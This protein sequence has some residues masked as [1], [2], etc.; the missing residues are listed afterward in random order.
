MVRTSPSRCGESRTRGRG[1]SGRAKAHVAGPSWGRT[2]L[3]SERGFDGGFDD[4]TGFVGGRPAIDELFSATYEELRRMAASVRATDAR[5]TLNPTALVNEAWLKLAASRSL[6]VASVLHFKRIAARAIRQVLV[7]AARQRNADKRGAGVAPV[8]FEEALAP[9]GE[10]RAEDV[11][12]IDNAL[13]E[14]RRM[15]PRHAA[16]V[17]SRFFGGLEIPEIAQLLNVSEATVLRDW[18]AARA[19]LAKELRGGP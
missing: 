12:A 7:E 5:A 6:Q 8:V 9:A 15:N 13:D 10:E 4:L 11:I 14:L 16:M 17:E 1:G 2:R 3:V 18:R 19:W